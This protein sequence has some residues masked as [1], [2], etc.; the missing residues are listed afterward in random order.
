MRPLP[1]QDGFTILGLLVAVAVINIGLGI[2]ATSWVTIDRRADE[3]ELIWRGQQY[4]RALNCHQQATGGLPEE[5]S[6]LL[7]SDC[8]RALYPDPMSA[9]GEWRI[10]R[11]GDPELQP[12]QAGQGEFLEMNIMELE[13]RQDSRSQGGR[14]QGGLQSDSFRQSFDRFRALSESLRA[15]FAGNNRIVGVMSTK[16]G[17]ALRLYKEE[18]TY[19]KWR[20]V[21]GQ[22]GL[23]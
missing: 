2:A 1:D 15:R 8:I 10:L 23:Q 11:Q 12:N 5:L 21:V 4:V 6:E 7:E 13:A 22:T 19:D 16:T 3:A 17:E 20:F 9:D 18:S 14:R